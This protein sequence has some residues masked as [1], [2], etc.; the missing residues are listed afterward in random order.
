MSRARRLLTALRGRAGREARAEARLEEAAEAL[1]R[2]A[3]LLRA[4]LAADAAWEEVAR[5]A[6]PCEDPA[7]RCCP[8][9]EARRRAVHARW[10][11]P[12]DPE[13]AAITERGDGDDADPWALA[14]AALAAARRAGA[15]PSAV[16]VRLADALEAGLDAARARRSAAAGP[17]ATARLLS[18]LP[19]GGLGLAWLLGMGPVELLATPLGWML[20]VLGGALTA[21]GRAWTRLAVRRA[22]G[23]ESEADPAVVLDVAAALLGAG[24]SL[25][26]ALDDVA[27]CLPGAQDLRVVTTLL[28]WGADWDEAWEPVA[29]RPSWRTLGERLRPLH[30]TGMAGQGTLAAAAA[31][32][33]QAGRRADERAAEELAVRLVVPLGLCQLPA[34]VCWG[35]AP[36]ALALLGGG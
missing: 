22:A 24:R 33:R 26:A 30:R 35:V 17:R 21:A 32:L 28:R 27:V 10:A 9:H 14:D 19:V 29:D 34:F 31:G 12:P 20:L 8:H 16:A 4:G 6:P 18:W 36:M 25:P 11:L 23:D 15:A 2:W 1:R 3:A 13:G 7:K 5:G